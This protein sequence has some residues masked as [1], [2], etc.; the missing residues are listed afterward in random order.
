MINS[1]SSILEKYYEFIPYFGLAFI[2]AF[3]LTPIMGKI[4]KKLKAVDLPATQR[5]RDDKTLQQR[6]HKKAKPR[7][8]GLAIII[9][10]VLITLFT[11]NITPQLIGL[12]IGIGILTV[13]G[14]LDD[15]YEL[16]G[17]IKLPFQ[18]L[19]AIVVVVA[20]STIPSIQIAGQ[21]F[22]FT[23]WTTD[24][25]IF[26]YIYKFIFPADFISVFWIVLLINAINWVGGIDALEETVTFV[27]AITMMF[28]GVK[29]GN[30]ELAFLAVVL[31]GSILGFMPFNF[32]PSKILAGDAGDTVLG[33]TIAVLSIQVGAKFP[34]AI[35]VLIIPI[36]DMIWVL[37][38][39]L[40]RN[41]IRNP[42]NLLSISDRTHLHHRLLDLGYSGKQ[43]LFL[44]ATAI[45]IL[46]TVA[47][48]LTSMNT[49][50]LV[51]IAAS[52]VLIMFSLIGV[53]SKR[54]KDKLRRE[55]E[56]NKDLPPEP[57]P[58]EPSPE[59]KY[60]Y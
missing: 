47:F 28:I 29:L 38:G 11:Q 20:G 8:G 50:V 52:A 1:I 45:S 17:K 55:K 12:Y 4:A 41:R 48:Y 32:P 39:R 15:I 42:L 51:A 7:L 36:L 3:F 53:Y 31:S 27:A 13:V 23:A 59:S 40:K 22:D 56:L 5:R 10:F 46:A 19:A 34:T 6:I 30:P 49:L 57:T 9:P 25:D 14:V 26:G 2:I 35:L 33:F 60:A 37:F 43:V 58:D 18:L 24:I 44:E 54:K 21:F 16:S